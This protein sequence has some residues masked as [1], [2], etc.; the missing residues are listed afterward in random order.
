MNYQIKSK[1]FI[2]PTKKRNIWYII[3]NIAAAIV[4][5]GSIFSIFMNGIR[6]SNISAIIVAFMVTVLFRKSYSNQGHY[7][8]CIA[9]LQLDT[10]SVKIVFKQYDRLIEFYLQNIIKLEYSDQLNCL[11]IIGNGNVSECSKNKAEI[12]N[13]YLFYIDSIEYKDVLNTIENIIGKKIIY[14]DRINRNVL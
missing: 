7:E 8:F 14:V 1:L 4:A 12:I 5:I 9:E 6:I 11:R 2:N 10:R 3:L 13:E